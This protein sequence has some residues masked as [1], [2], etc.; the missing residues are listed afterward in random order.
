MFLWDKMTE[1][2][3]IARNVK[4]EM[5]VCSKKGLTVRESQELKQTV[6]K[7]QYSCGCMITSEV[8]IQS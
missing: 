2:S 4:N 3:S 1:A 7:Y 8:I 6:Q 5:C